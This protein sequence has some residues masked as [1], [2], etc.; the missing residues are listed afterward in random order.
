MYRCCIFRVPTSG[1]VSGRVTMIDILNTA[2]HDNILSD[3]VSLLFS[4][5][6]YA[7]TNVSRIMETCIICVII[8]F[9]KY[10]HS[11]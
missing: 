9:Y 8:M 5:T 7:I 11:T 10:L 6:I 1:A 4:G 2:E 3:W